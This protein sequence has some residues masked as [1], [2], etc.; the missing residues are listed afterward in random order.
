MKTVRQ[1]DSA[2]VEMVEDEDS[3]TEDSAAV[4][5]EEPNPRNKEPEGVEETERIRRKT[6]QRK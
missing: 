4:E 2:D 1:N 6:S 5:S 3:E